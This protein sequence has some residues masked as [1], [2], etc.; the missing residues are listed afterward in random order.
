MNATHSFP[1]TMRWYVALWRSGGTLSYS[2][3]FSF[4]DDRRRTI[5]F[6]LTALGRTV[7]IG[8]FGGPCGSRDL[9]FRDFGRRW[10]RYSVG[11]WR[12]RRC[13]PFSTGWM[14]ME[15]GGRRGVSVTIASR[16]LCVFRMFT[17]AELRARFDNPHR[18]TG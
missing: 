10:G 6:A 7:T 11:G 17:A 9:W 16:T 4:D 15:P 8:R 18:K 13:V 12:T 2:R 5:G 3:I 14:L 1:L